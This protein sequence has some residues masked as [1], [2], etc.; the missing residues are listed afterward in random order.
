VP[1]SKSRNSSPLAEGIKE[2]IK[3][4]TLQEVQYPVCLS[5]RNTTGALGEKNSKL[6]MQGHTVLINQK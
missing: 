4:R 1:P 5:L 6:Q 3:A 2:V